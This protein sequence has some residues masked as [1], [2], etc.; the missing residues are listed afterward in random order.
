[1][2]FMARRCAVVRTAAL[3]AS[4][5]FVLSGAGSTGADTVGQTM[6]KDP[7]ALFLA[8][9][10]LTATELATLERGGI[11]AKVVDTS[12][13]SEVFSVGAMRVRTTPSRVMDVL[14][15]V[16]GPRREPW[17]LQVGRLR[18]A[19]STRDVEALTLDPG[20]VKDLATCRLN[21]CEI[22]LPADAIERFRKEV[23]WSSSSRAA[24]ANAVFRELLST[25]ARAYL[26]RGN[27]ALYRYDNNDDPVWISD[28]VQ[29]LMNR[30]SFLRAAAPD[31]Y[32]FLE[33]FPEARPADVEDFIYWMKEKFW[34]LTVLSLNHVTLV[35][36]PTDSGRLILAVSKQLYANH[37]Y[38][39]SLGVTA[40][41]E[42]SHGAGAYLVF[43][44]RTR[45]D[46]RRGGFTWV[47]RVL[48]RFLVRG[49]L[50]GHFKQL[51]LRLEAP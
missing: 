13:R 46:I 14:R 51:R 16:D 27:E 4:C 49:R 19:P 35:D 44:N 12:D 3:L 5:S 37:Y 15:D 30:S 18:A 42:R 24:R 22:R 7:A 11:V 45:A 39:S 10:R 43:I 26:A 23:D 38:E 21:H 1:M 17:V 25:Y 28:S 47:E 9:G 20:D 50:E 34:L 33:R 32:M 6:E 40:F 2:E 48:L 31:L 8:E 41:V 29:Q 36:R